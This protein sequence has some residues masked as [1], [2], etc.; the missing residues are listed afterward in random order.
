MTKVLYAS[1]TLHKEWH[2]PKR[3]VCI[4]VHDTDEQFKK[5]VSAYGPGTPLDGWDNAVGAFHP[6]HYREI[7]NGHTKRWESK[8]NK[9]FAGV[10]RTSQEYMNDDLIIHECVHAAATIFRMDV[11]RSVNLG[12]DCLLFEEY[13]AYMVGDLSAQV[14]ISLQ[15]GGVW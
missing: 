12:S 8:T 3:Y 14:L 7:F 13:F 4:V 1:T 11:R 15:D 5:A 6:I 10:I 9:H 2:G